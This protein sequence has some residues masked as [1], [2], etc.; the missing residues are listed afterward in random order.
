M[1]GSE[2]LDQKLIVEFTGSGGQFSDAGSPLGKVLQVA[3]LL[4]TGERN[5][6]GPLF[7]AKKHP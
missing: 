1:A 2:G 3:F 4:G 6:L 5:G 7:H